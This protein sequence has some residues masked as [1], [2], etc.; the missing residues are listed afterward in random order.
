[1]TLATHAIT[2]L[3]RQATPPAD[4]AAGR[5][6]VRDSLA[7]L[8][9]LETAVPGLSGPLYFDAMRSTPPTLSFGLFDFDSLL[10]APLQYRAV[11]DPSTV[12]LAAD[13]AAGLTFEVDGQTYRQY[14]VAYV[15]SISTRFPI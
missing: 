10:S 2:D 6:A 13:Q 8:D 11:K 5:L 1:M 12:D 4:A 3:H 7:A 15:E 14:R 9:H